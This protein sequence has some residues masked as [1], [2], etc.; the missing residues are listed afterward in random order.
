MASLPLLGPGTPDESAVRSARNVA[1]ALLAA[2]LMGTGVLSMARACALAGV[3]PF[4]ILSAIAALAAH[5]TAV[6]LV[7]ASTP[8]SSTI[9]ALCRDAFGPRMEWF[10][11]VVI[12]LQ[13]VGACTGYVVVIGDTFAPLL[14][15]WL[16]TSH[17]HKYEVRITLMALIVLPVSLIRNL[18]GLRFTSAISVT[19][20]CIFCLTVVANGLVVLADQ[21]ERR[22]SLMPE[23]VHLRGPYWG[24]RDTG[25]LR[26]LG[27]IVFAY[28]MHQN[29][30]AVFSTLRK[31]T[32]DVDVFA[33]ACGRAVSVVCCA[34][35][36]VGLAGYASFLSETAPDL[37]T[38]FLV[39]GTYISSA[40]NVVR[41]LYGTGLLLAFPMMLWE[42]RA[43]T[44]KL[45]S[46]GEGE[47]EMS[48]SVHVVLTV[49]LIALTTLIGCL[50]SDLGTVFGLIGSTCAPL[51]AYVFP[52]VLYLKSGE[53][54]KDEREKTAI[55][56]A[57]LGGVFICLG[58]A[59][60]ACDVAG[61]WE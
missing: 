56:I 20:I 61:V 26:S 21:D 24:P 46:R 12:V 42:A 52:A 8:L 31:T 57:V 39:K 51:L 37:L 10:S 60:W 35:I 34:S 19:V 55:G 54:R 49:A 25:A 3:V 6:F 30:L 18:S 48:Y 53:A 59:V 7:K 32:G 36:A 47:Q 16:K 23:H 28:F 11:C 9:P 58:V 38:N 50:V 2:S 40:F 5:V 45:V 44:F 4:V 29:V 14:E 17:L 13:Q 22:E 27:L 43:N 33:Q 41:A 1:T 15:Y